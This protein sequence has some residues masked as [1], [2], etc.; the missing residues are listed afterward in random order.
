MATRRIAFSRGLLL[1]LGVFMQLAL[2]AVRGNAQAAGSSSLGSQL[3]SPGASSA[4]SSSSRAGA[5]AP[6]GGPIIVPKDIS[7]LRIEPG[8]LLSVNVYDNPELSSSYRVDL[9]GDLK[10]PLC[11]KVNLRGLT[12]T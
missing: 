4:A 3:P 5:A 9:A 1:L 10:L 7:E 2:M 8:D 6:S 11:G 12:L